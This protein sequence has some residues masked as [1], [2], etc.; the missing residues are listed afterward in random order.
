MGRGARPSGEFFKEGA[1]LADVDGLIIPANPVASGEALTVGHTTDKA[2]PVPAGSA[3]RFGELY[4]GL[5]GVV[6]KF[7]VLDPEGGVPGFVVCVAVHWSSVVD[8]ASIRGKRDQW[9]SEMCQ[10]PNWLVSGA[11]VRISSAPATSARIASQRRR[12]SITN[13]S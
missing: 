7:I 8:V 9:R 10:Y 4:D 5:G 13:C 3:V 6:Q 2:P 11:G 12:W 1:H